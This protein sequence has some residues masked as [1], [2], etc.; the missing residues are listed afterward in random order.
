MCTCVLF[1]MISSTCIPHHQHLSAHVRVV[2]HDLKHLHPTPPA[3]VCARACCF[4]R[5]VGNV[6]ESD[7]KEIST[8]KGDNKLHCNEIMRSLCFMPYCV[9]CTT[10]NVI[11]VIDARLNY[12]ENSIIP[13]L[14]TKVSLFVQTKG[15]IN[16]SSG[17][18]LITARPFSTNHVIGFVS[19]ALS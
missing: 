5:F 9:V 13:K 10:G 16:Q 2:S 12:S 1:H 3:S 14:G 11:K 4:T 6:L 17:I 8:Q 18:G 7:E 15:T 19:I